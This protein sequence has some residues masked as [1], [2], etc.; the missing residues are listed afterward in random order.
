[1]DLPIR[2]P[3]EADVIAEEAARF[4]ALSPEARLRSVRGMIATG[5]FLIRNS[6]KAAYLH[7]Y[8]A[9]Q[10]EESRRAV[11]GFIARHGG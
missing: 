11:R 8:T 10:E 4:R 2:F 3:D 6:P 9:A 1:M 7:A 5:S